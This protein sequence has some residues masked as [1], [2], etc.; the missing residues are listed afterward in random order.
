MISSLVWSE[1]TNQLYEVLGSVTEDARWPIIVKSVKSIVF[2]LY[3]FLAFSQ[4]HRQQLYEESGNLLLYPTPHCG[5][6]F[7]TLFVT[8]KRRRIKTNAYYADSLK[9][10]FWLDLFKTNETPIYIAIF[11]CLHLQFKEKQLR[12]ILQSQTI[13]FNK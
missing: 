12:R 3:I 5:R 10:T 9:I 2:C 6:V 8:A 13:I 1:K 7:M 11:Y 4:R